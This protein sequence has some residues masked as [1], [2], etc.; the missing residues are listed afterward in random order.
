MDPLSKDELKGTEKKFVDI[1][2]TNKLYIV[3]IEN[4]FKCKAKEFN[5]WLRGIGL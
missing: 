3:S 5:E 2:E 1:D 4:G